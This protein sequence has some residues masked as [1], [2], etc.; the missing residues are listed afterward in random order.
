M[1]LIHN[2]QKITNS[3]NFTLSNKASLAHDEKNKHNTKKIL[4][5]TFVKKKIEM[6]KLM[7]TLQSLVNCQS[8]SDVFCH[9]S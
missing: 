9:A 4:S 2:I 5:Y 1:Q 7:M 6:I 3:L 8:V